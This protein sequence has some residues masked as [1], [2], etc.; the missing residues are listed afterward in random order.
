MN[1]EL[2]K[3][4]TDNVRQLNELEALAMGIRADVDPDTSVFDHPT[5]GRIYAKEF[6]GGL[7]VIIGSEI[8][9]ATQNSDEY[10][11]VLDILS[12]ATEIRVSKNRL[13]E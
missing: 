6:N 13:Q 1:A 8:I 2:N 5:I 12:E 10:Y 7:R 11:K 9:S 4:L 3:E